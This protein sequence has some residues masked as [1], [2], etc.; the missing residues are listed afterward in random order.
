MKR[1]ISG[2]IDNK[3]QLL[4]ISNTQVQCILHG[5]LH[6]ANKCNIEAEN[7][8]GYEVYVVLD[9]RFGTGNDIL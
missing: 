1:N 2:D 7:L 9:D 8:H 6:F 4:E 3:P 5:F